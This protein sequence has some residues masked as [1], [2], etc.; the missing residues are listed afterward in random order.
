M[1]HVLDDPV[2][3]LYVVVYLLLALK[4]AA[5]GSYT[6]VLRIRRKVYA[7]PE[8]YALQGLAVRT[9]RDEDIERVRRA[10]QNDLENILPFFVVGFLYLLTGPSYTAAAIYLIGYLV[11][12]TLH[13]VFYIASLQPYR[14]I[15]FTL[16]GIFTLGMIVQTFLAVARAS[17]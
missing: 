2:V 15:A 5:V 14:T 7:T 13:S 8:D 16:G 10:H 9:T 1:P 12:R 4:M 11:A 3:R 17:G 6:S